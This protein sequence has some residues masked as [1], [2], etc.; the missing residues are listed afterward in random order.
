MASDCRHA[1]PQ[2]LDYNQLR[3]LIKLSYWN[4]LFTGYLSRKSY[5]TIN[6]HMISHKKD[7]IQAY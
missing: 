7:C 4:C 2:A 5:K 3:R 6:V 1:L